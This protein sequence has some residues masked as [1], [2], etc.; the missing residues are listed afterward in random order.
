MSEDPTM[1]QLEKRIANEA[2]VDK[3]HLN[4]AIK[5][6]TSAEKTH[7]NSIKVYLICFL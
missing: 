2:H 7:N 5:D 4:H 6:L 3:K 1:R